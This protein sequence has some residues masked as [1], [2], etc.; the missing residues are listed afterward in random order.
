MTIRV[1]HNYQCLYYGLLGLF[2]SNKT[3]AENCCRTSKFYKWS[4]IAVVTQKPF[5]I[6]PTIK[7][8]PN[9]KV[10]FSL[11][12]LGIIYSKVIYSKVLIQTKSCSIVQFSGKHLVVTSTRMAVTDP[13]KIMN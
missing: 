10:L 6:F 12:V 11:T 5:S 4:A 1:Y 3:I 2:I 8:N 13:A 9:Q 7:F